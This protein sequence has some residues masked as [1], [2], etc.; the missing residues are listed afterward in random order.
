MKIKKQNV[1]QYVFGLDIGTRS[2]VGTVGYKSG[3]EFYVLGQEVR[4]HETRA[5]LDG[6][7]HDI[8]KVG[9]TIAEVK[10]ALENKLNMQLHDVCI[11][12]A[13]RVLRTIDVHSDME[14]SSDLI[15]TEEE[16][17]QLIS[18]SIEKAYDEFN[19]I[20]NSNEKFYCVGHSVSKYYLND[21]M[22]CVGPPWNL[23]TIDVDFNACIKALYVSSDV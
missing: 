9:E 13:G 18:Q 7:I 15:V 3:D 14:F 23:N 2:I 10:E 8:D 12:A 4:E 6:Q 1:N 5:M 19:I 17:Y 20:N 11:A 21:N 22:P 16:I